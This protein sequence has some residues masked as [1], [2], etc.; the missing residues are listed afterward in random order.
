MQQF[1]LFA[2]E[3]NPNIR[4]VL[5]LVGII[6]LLQE[7]VGN[8]MREAGLLLMMSVMEEEARHVVGEWWPSSSSRR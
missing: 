7:G 5:P 8:L 3:I 1:R 2:T 4:M 6:S